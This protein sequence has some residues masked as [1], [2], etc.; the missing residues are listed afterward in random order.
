[1]EY[2][3]K[4]D[5]FS[6]TFK[7]GKKTYPILNEVSLT[8]SAGET[9]GISGASG[10]GKSM[11]AKA[12]MGL[13]T[14]MPGITYDGS[15]AFQG[16]NMYA[17]ADNASNKLRGK[18]ITMII[19]QP[20]SAFNPLLTIDK[21]LIETFS[22]DKQ[23]R[24]KEQLNFEINELL[25]SVGLPENIIKRYPHQLSA[26]QLQRIMAVMAVLHQPSLIIADEATASL[27][28]SAQKDVMRLLIEQRKKHNSAIM[29]ISH[30][31]ELLRSVS[32]RILLLN[33]G[34]VEYILNQPFNER[35]V[36][37]SQAVISDIPEKNKNNSIT[38]TEDAALLSCTN[39][40]KS[41]HKGN[42][43]FGKSSGPNPVLQNISFGLMK[44]SITALLGLSGSGKS[45]IGR[46][47][48]GLD[49]ADSGEILYKGKILNTESFKR[50][51]QLRREIQMV[52]Q[53]PVS[54]FNPALVLM[55]Q[56]SETY[57]HINETASKETLY[58]TLRSLLK[59][60]H[61]TEDC[62]M[63]YPSEL[64]GGQLQRLSL[65][66][67]LMGESELIIFDESLSALDYENQGLLIEMIKQMAH[68]H[69]KTVLF[70][71]HDKNLVKVLCDYVLVLHEG[72]IAESGPC[73]E[74]TASPAHVFTKSFFA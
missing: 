49:K 32:D 66:R 23:N 12:A 11:L 39:L 47:L 25:S 18:E 58:E 37:R 73:S 16:K 22:I 40:I 70:I 4:V 57:K 43:L 44:G 67:I 48:A 36:F 53:D 55:D 35:P 62:L 9:L 38:I 6:A 15:I 52:F 29:L 27:D 10:S 8:I 34:R 26:G 61:L 50:N 74:V 63:K 30:D 69:H 42:T 5:H 19:Q 72:I 71:T 24:T 68:V 1:M 31:L 46:I 60:M 56:L 20:Q 33:N 21:Q 2:I 45:T 54:S 51:K 65:A 3:L 13:L 17:C 28:I 64:S 14:Y 59:Q 7:M 41:F